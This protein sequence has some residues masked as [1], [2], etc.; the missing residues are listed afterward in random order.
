MAEKEHNIYFLNTSLLTCFL[1]RAKACERKQSQLITQAV[2]PGFKLRLFFFP[3][4]VTNHRL[5][6]KAHV[7]PMHAYSTWN[8]Q[9]LS[10]W[11]DSTDSMISRTMKSHTNEH[12]IHNRPTLKDVKHFQ[13]GSVCKPYK[14]S[15]YKQTFWVN[16]SRIMLYQRS[17]QPGLSTLQL[18]KKHHQ[19][20]H[21]IFRRDCEPS[22]ILARTRERLSNK[23]R[24]VREFV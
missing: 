7:S 9:K 10:S 4:S 18:H 21:C 1:Q 23:S 15:I 16:L 8:L 12:T 22:K 3:H 19:K 14:T 11:K 2:R 5:V 24:K 20:H 6:S 13:N 17:Y